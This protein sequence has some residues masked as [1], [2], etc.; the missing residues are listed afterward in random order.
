M[1]VFNSFSK[2]DDKILEFK[3]NAQ[4]EEIDPVFKYWFSSAKFDLMNFYN[5]EAALVNHK[6]I[7]ISGCSIIQDRFRICQLL[8]VLPKYRDIYR[9][10]LIRKNG[11]IFMHLESAK[12]LNL[13]KVFYTMHAENKKT[14]K[15]LK[16][17]LYKRQH[18]PY[19]KNFDYKGIIYINN[20]Y[21]HCFEYIIQ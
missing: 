13:Q 9:D 18:Y 11:F 19:I 5:I 16:V 7:A 14:E 2:D 6:I 21:Q 4:R 1:V 8:Y 10:L 20:C 17:M 15:A 3:Y 12:K